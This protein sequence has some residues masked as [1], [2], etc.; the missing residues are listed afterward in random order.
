MWGCSIVVGASAGHTDW[1][2]YRC[3]CVDSMLLR[4]HIVQRWTAVCRWCVEIVAV[5]RADIVH[6]RYTIG[7]AKRDSIFQR[8]GQPR[9]GVDFTVLRMAKV[10]NTNVS[11]I[12]MMWTGMDARKGAD[13]FSP[14]RTCTQKRAAILQSSFGF[15]HTLFYLLE[16]W[17]MKTIGCPIRWTLRYTEAIF[18]FYLKEK[19]FV[20][21]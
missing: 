8:F 12:W 3:Q 10:W 14:E 6:I 4:M 13:L 2:G 15:F 16:C 7:A 21:H 1:C 18:R 19:L 20:Q 5:D 17:L 9:C 11:S